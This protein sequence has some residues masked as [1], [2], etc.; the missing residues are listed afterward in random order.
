[1]KEQIPEVCKNIFEA[2]V[3]LGIFNQFSVGF[4]FGCLLSAFFYH[5]ASRERIKRDIQDRKRESELL[6]QLAVKDKR[7]DALHAMLER[8]SVKGARK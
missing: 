3:K 6:K 8:I 5:L 7:I 4:V 2:G 1:M